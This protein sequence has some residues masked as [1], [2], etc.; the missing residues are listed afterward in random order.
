MA[1]RK[2]KIV[3]S[4]LSLDNAH[5]IGVLNRGEVVDEAPE[6]FAPTPELFHI[7]TSGWWSAHAPPAPTIHYPDSITQDVKPE[8]MEQKDWDR[9][10]DHRRK[11]WRIHKVD[12]DPR[13]RHLYPYF[14]FPTPRGGQVYIPQ[15]EHEDDSSMW[16][17]TK[18]TKALERAYLR[19]DGFYEIETA[20]GDVVECITCGGTK[21]IRGNPD[22]ID[23]QDF[24]YYCASPQCLEEMA[25]SDIKFVVDYLSGNIPNPTTV[26]QEEETH[27]TPAP[28]QEYQV[29]IYVD[30]LVNWGG[31]E[32]FKWK[33]SCHMSTDDHSPEGLEALHRFAR[34]I[35]LRR[36][37]FQ[38]HY[39][40][41][42]YDLNKSRR[43]VAVA[44]GVIELSCQDM[45]R[46]CGTKHTKQVQE[47]SLES[48]KRP[49]ISIPFFGKQEAS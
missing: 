33:E 1:K 8:R 21:R 26:S 28:K 4:K 18:R 40:M 22:L 13:F 23:G 11:M 24:L 7:E 9:A 38:D 32:T 14:P 43:G 31:S 29:T 12:V 39:L 44:R 41:P 35:G 5:Q 42:H 20:R 34:S 25:H 17:I 46:T 10:I 30:D 3:T 19:A 27:S 45:H 36:D 16:H 49:V 2:P 37:W 48:P 47:T 6:E 15:W